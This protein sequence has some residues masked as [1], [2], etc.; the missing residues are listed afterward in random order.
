MTTTNKNPAKVNLQND[1]RFT[2]PEDDHRNNPKFRKAHPH[3]KFEGKRKPRVLKHNTAHLVAKHNPKTKTIILAPK[4]NISTQPRPGELPDS[5]V[6]PDKEDMNL[7]VS[8]L[9]FDPDEG[10]DIGGFLFHEIAHEMY[11][12]NAD[13]E[14]NTGTNS[15]P[16]G[17][18]LGANTSTDT[19]LLD[20]PTAL[21]IATITIDAQT[22][23]TDGIPTYMASLGFNAADFGNDFEIRILK[24]Q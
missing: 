7:E 17:V 12:A 6:N 23:S 19:V 18:T 1:F 4:K 24:Q 5:G 21:S 2:L 14:L 22:L 11:D 9:T 8:G 13:M 16:A 3:V 10:A 15:A 20:P